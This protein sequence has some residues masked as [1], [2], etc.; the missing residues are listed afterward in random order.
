MI[1]QRSRLWI[2]VFVIGRVLL[3]D[4]LAGAASEDDVSEDV[5]PDY[6]YF[7]EEG[8][9]RA[10]LAEED[11]NASEIT[12]T[13][14]KTLTETST[15]TIT[16]SSTTMANTTTVTRTTS[17]STMTA[18]ITVV[19]TTKTD[20]WTELVCTGSIELKVLNSFQ[21]S[22][23]ES[24]KE[25]ITETIAE[26][27]G[28]PTAVTTLRI[29]PADAR[30]LSW[31]RQLQSQTQ[32]TVDFEVRLWYS[33]PSQ[34]EDFAGSLQLRFVAATTESMTNLLMAGL[35]GTPLECIDG[36]YTV[37]MV[38]TSGAEVALLEPTYLADGLTATAEK[39]SKD[40]EF[41]VDDGGWQ[42]A[43]VSIALV[44]LTMWTS[45][46]RRS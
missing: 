14:T 1:S 31:K 5:H 41:T 19:T 23:D 29:Y 30:R 17:T 20:Q 7:Q 33:S 12:E 34:A 27:L 46:W 39:N 38:M 25:A 15:S 36:S 21:L 44:M 26:W 13:L 10:L 8:T 42:N 3:Q 45:E 35:P 43:A 22:E 18:T 32:A 28:V 37:S 9:I 16:A 4:S 40:E 2:H 24:A 6:Y 11:N